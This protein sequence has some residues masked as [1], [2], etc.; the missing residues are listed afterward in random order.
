M[1]AGPKGSLLKGSKRQSYLGRLLEAETGAIRKKEALA[2]VC[3][4]YPNTY[5]VGMSNLGFQTVYRE[6]NSRPDT[7]CQ[8]G[9][10]EP[11]L[12]SRSLEEARPFRAFDILAFSLTFELDYINLL[13]S[14][15]ASSIPLLA[16]ERDESHPL[17]I[18]GGP[19]VME[20]PE[21][22]ADFI[23]LFV[24]GEAE[25]LIHPFM[26]RYLDL[27]GKKRRH[28][29][30]WELS[31]LEGLYGPRFYK[32]LHT[33]EERLLKMQPPPAPL[34]FPVKRVAT[35][36]LDEHPTYSTILTPY[37]EFAMAFMVE[38]ARGCFRDCRFCLARAIYKPRLRSLS[39]LQAIIEGAEGKTTYVALVGSTLSDYP[40]LE[41]LV[42]LILE[43]GMTFSVSSLRADKPQQFLL[44]G[45]QQSG[46]RSITLAPETAS[47]QLR[48]R[49]CKRIDQE[50]FFR[51]VEM[52]LHSG[53]KDIKL[54]Y[55]IGLPGEEDQDAL[56]IAHQAKKVLSI[57]RGM[58]KATGHMG[59]LTLGINPLVPKPFTPMERDAMAPHQV[60]KRRLGIIK[61]ELAR[62]ANTKILHESLWA[63]LLQGII[64]RG[65]REVGKLLLPIA[66]GKETIPS[67]LRKNPSYAEQFLKKQEGEVLPWQVI[68]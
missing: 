6:L 51:H 16:E 31:A 65:S 17:I 68:Q 37:T 7:Y 9:F 54:Y 67:A 15:M 66:R 29:L 49:I 57:M 25:E 35:S 62:E 30:L 61:K 50:A 28:E 60:L 47:D 32:P 52:A 18:A 53:L 34:A 2:H 43:K 4:I 40:W 42:E 3:L 1:R 8:R 58:A 22:L 27:R 21:P 5:H 48:E 46:Q 41:Q 59:T 13:K 45:L 44:K 10:V 36:S 38:V 11:F 19:C 33:P 24:V 63:T 20:N 55:L 23:D 64:A 56:A 14:L 12:Q 39:I 26:Q